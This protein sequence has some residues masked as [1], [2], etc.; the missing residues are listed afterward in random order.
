[1]R[2][3]DPFLK[4]FRKLTIT[5]DFWTSILSNLIQSSYHSKQLF[6]YVMD[7]PLDKK[8][9]FEE[10]T[11]DSIPSDLFSLN[12]THSFES[13]TPFHLSFFSKSQVFSK[14]MGQ[15]FTPSYISDFI[16]E[17]TLSY[18]IEINNITYL[19]QE[20]PNI[21]IADIAA[22]TGNLLISTLYA[23]LK[24][25]QPFVNTGRKVFH[26]FLSENIYA[27]D[28]DP[29]T[30][31]IQKL[32]VLFFSSLFL[33]EFDLPN[34]ENNFCIGNSLLDD[35]SLV[36]KSTSTAFKPLRI[37]SKEKSIKFDL[38]VSN[39]PYMSYG[40]RDAQKYHPEFK[41]FL[42]TRFLSSEYKLSLYPIFIE[43]SLELLNEKGVLGIITPDSHLLGRYY[44]KIRSY[45]LNNSN[46]LDISLLGFEPF[47][48]VTLGR[49]TITFY[50]KNSGTRR[51]KIPDSFPARWFPSLTS[52]L[53][54]EWEDFPNSQ[55]DFLKSEYNRFYL[56]FNLQDK[57]YVEKWKEKAKRKLNDMVTIHTGVRS[58]VG[59]K[60]IV[61]KIKK[62]D[63]WKEGIISG[64]QI[65]PFQIEYQNDWI[66]VTPSILWSGGFNKEIVEK[67]KIVLRQT[68]YNIIAAVD[69]KG[70]YHLNNCHSV[71]PK[72][73]S[74]NLYA[75]ATQLNSQ[76]FNKVYGI[77][78][79]ERGR[80]LAQID[81]DFLLN[82]PIITTTK[83]QEIILEEFYR[84]QNRRQLQ[85]QI[86]EEYVLLDFLE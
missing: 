64:R 38:I 24:R 25:L 20:L 16:A 65:R 43:R 50:S 83:G 23:I 19:E 40:L 55:T 37:L 22:G 32:R 58:K 8:I 72:D 9:S 46:L 41:H 85:N 36:D 3:R 62:G 77:L 6:D 79:I 56:Y 27:F 7:T 33:P 84:E 66:N 26:N 42:R 76:E 59:Q 11:R 82:L 81:I 52:F 70:Y 12:E 60:N 34:L 78:S 48:G 75:L 51:E 80:S 45:I 39:P 13:L 4:P 18:F 61:G 15:F 29:F 69:E 73:S 14:K 5:D 35:D 21:T 2:N 57:E 31:F 63:S 53:E 17:N 67:P 68:G 49:P 47:K 71:S 1:M 10:P 30:L 74:L 44:S 86:V 28:L 54:Q